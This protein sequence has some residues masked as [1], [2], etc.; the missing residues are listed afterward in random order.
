VV[1]E[2]IKKKK[3]KKKNQVEN[4]IKNIKCLLWLKKKLESAFGVVIAY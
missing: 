1:Q 2:C 3:K 4:Q